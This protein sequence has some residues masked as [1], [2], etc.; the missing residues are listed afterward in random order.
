MITVLGASGFI[1]SHLT[2]YLQHNYD[3]FFAPEN[4][5]ETIYTKHLGHVI[6]AI[7]ITSD[8]RE[9]PMAC[10][11]A[12]VCLLHRLI[13]EGNFESLTYL[14]STRVYGIGKNTSENSE[15]TVNPNRLDDIYNISKLMGES[16]VIHSG[17]P[18]MKVVRLS[19]VLG[20]NQNPDTFLG[21]LLH[22]GFKTGSITFHQ[23]LESAKDFIHIDDVV[24]FLRHIAKLSE[25]GIYNIAGGETISN[26]DIADYMESIL[27][28][29]TK[30]ADNAPIRSF[31]KITIDKIVESFG[32]K[33]RSFSDYFPELLHHYHKDSHV[34]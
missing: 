16:I 32:V 34:S 6:Y 31:N 20:E 29:E 23:A 8:F 27:G 11:D 26:A 22:E 5:D 2:D 33:P 4:G 17:H 19:N 28:F 3:D 18:C 25:S 13:Q 9:H 24:F 10:I 7:G 12:H 30:V 15:L 14:S 1:G 21:Q